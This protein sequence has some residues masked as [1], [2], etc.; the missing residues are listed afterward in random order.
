MGIRVHKELGYGLVD[1]KVENFRIVDERIN[2]EGIL[3]EHGDRWESEAWSREKYLEYL[4]QLA[5]HPR[6][7]ST[8]NMELLNQ[9]KKLPPYIE[10]FGEDANWDL[11]NLETNPGWSPIDSVVHQAEFGLPNVLLIIPPC[12]EKEW[13][14]YDDPID[15]VEETQLQVQVNR[16]VVLKQGLY[17]WDGLRMDS[18]SGKVFTGEEH[19]TL[20]LFRR[21]TLSL[22]AEP[23]GEDEEKVARLL[24]SIAEKLGFANREE[25]EQFIAPVVPKS[26]QYL[27]QFAKIFRDWKTVFQLRPMIYVYWC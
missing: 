17:P 5:Y 16:V 13:R 22:K 19:Q 20:T 2:P 8:S 21:L 26:V 14:R 6:E 10:M 24:Q 7:K 9:G 3:G 4:E 25:C 1:L 18:R 15:Y 27:C 12:E 23:P 11:N